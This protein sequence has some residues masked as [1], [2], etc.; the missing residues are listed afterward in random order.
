MIKLIQLILSL[1]FLVIIH[2]LGHFCFARLWKVRVNKFYMFFNPQ[3]SIV[4][5]KKFDGRWHVR[6]FAPNTTEDDEWGQH[7]DSTEWGIG[8]VP[9]GGYC[10]IAG[11]VD[12]TSKAED[13]AKTPAQPW[14]FRSKNVWQRMTI[15]LGGIFVNFIAALIIFGAIF[16]HWGSDSLP[17]KNV[18]RGLYYSALMQEEGFAQ[19]D[20]IIAID[21]IQPEE[22]GDIV[23][24]LIIEGKRN[25][26]VARG[27]DTICL[28]MSEDLGTRLLSLQNE[29]QRQENQH[30]RRD[31]SYTKRNYVL[32]SEFFPF[33]IDSVAEGTAADLGGLMAKDSIVSIN[34][35]ATPAF[36]MVQNELSLHPC[37]SII[38]GLYRQGE[39]M[40]CGLFLGD[41]CQMGVIAR[42]K[43]DYFAT[44]HT[45]YSLLG[46]AKAG[47]CYGWDTL[48][49]YI[50]QFRL[51]FTKEGA[52]SIGGFGAI[53]SMFPSLWNWYAFWHMTA[54]LSLILAF[55]NFLPIPALDGGYFLF[56]LV[57]LFSGKQPSD[58]FLERA[59]TVG[60]WLL[61]ALLVVANFNDVIRFFF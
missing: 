1:S 29:F 24:W 21:G 55:M 8:W 58:K 6:F 38:V 3:F 52:Q 30:A 10:A 9:F 18:D 53:G 54:F 28:T 33:V 27:E 32:I 20:K 23:Q 15:I 48:V 36:M 22:L 61:I 31:P 39:Y 7:P 12:E 34:G 35:I 26:V 37:D 45:D 40:E 4:R 25:V 41:K 46:A 11:M 57:E 60:F 49:M 44:E 50:K 17:L 56:L 19:G 14:E 47:I 59:N 13:L 16:H 2:E 5:F 43:Y 42:S 51:V